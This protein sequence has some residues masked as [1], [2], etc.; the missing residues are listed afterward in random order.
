MHHQRTYT[1]RLL[2]AG[3]A[4]AVQAAMHCCPYLAVLNSTMYCWF[5]CLPVRRDVR[6][7]VLQVT[8]QHADSFWQSL[9]NTNAMGPLLIMALYAGATSSLHRACPAMC[10]VSERFWPSE[11]LLFMAAV[12]LFVLRAACAMTRLVPRWN[13]VEKKPPE[14]GL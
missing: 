5:N 13:A 12:G 14:G 4:A 10:R 11:W 8:K 2:Q 7:F 1:R 9:I 3:V 6:T